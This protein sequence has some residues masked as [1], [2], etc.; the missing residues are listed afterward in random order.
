MDG[1][2]HPGAASPVLDYLAQ[3]VIILC[4]DLLAADSRNPEIFQSSWLL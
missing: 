3:V 4:L 2:L 1:C